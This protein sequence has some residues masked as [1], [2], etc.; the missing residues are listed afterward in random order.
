MQIPSNVTDKSQFIVFVGEIILCGLHAGILIIKLLSLVA[1]LSEMD[2]ER[3]N[4]HLF[5]KR[6]DIKFTCMK[7][8][9]N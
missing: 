3:D 1:V 6:M 8:N 5:S 2:T 4:I 9:K 7:I